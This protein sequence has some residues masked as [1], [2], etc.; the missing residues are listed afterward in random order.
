MVTDRDGGRWLEYGS[1]LGVVVDQRGTDGMS[2]GGVS[3]GGVTRGGVT[4]GG[5]SGIEISELDDID[6]RSTMSLI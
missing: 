1:G 5:V 2:R 6:M 4:R 3:G